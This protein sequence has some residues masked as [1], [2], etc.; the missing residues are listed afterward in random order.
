MALCVLNCFP[1]RRMECESTKLRFVLRMK[2]AK[3]PI[4]MLYFVFLIKNYIVKLCFFNCLYHVELV[5]KIKHIS[6]KYKQVILEI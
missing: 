2:A 1:I 5:G 4:S 6:K 3:L